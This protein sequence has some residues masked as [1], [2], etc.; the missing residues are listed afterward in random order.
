MPFM[1]AVARQTLTVEE[2]TEDLGVSL[3]SMK[4]YL[5]TGSFVN[6]ASSS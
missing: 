4:T 6:S 1:S 3:R 2:A 5:A